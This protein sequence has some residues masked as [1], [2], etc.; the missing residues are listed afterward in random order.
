MKIREEDALKEPENQ[1]RAVDFLVGNTPN[2]TAIG[3]GAWVF[4]RVILKLNKLAYYRMIRSSKYIDRLDGDSYKQVKNTM[5]DFS[6]RYLIYYVDELRPC[7]KKWGMKK[8]KRN[9]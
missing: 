6:W 4:F 3:N 2:T 7:F 9:L 5:I 8:T 1:S